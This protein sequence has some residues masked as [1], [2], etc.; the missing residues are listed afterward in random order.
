M[1]VRVTISIIV[2]LPL[3][4]KNNSIHTTTKDKKINPYNSNLTIN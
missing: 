3:I 4:E 1:N 2:I